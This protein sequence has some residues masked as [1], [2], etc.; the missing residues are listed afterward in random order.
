MLAVAAVPER[1]GATGSEEE[2]LERSGDLDLKR[3]FLL[4]FFNSRCDTPAVRHCNK[5]TSSL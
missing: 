4:L 1:F 5:W 2:K 3:L